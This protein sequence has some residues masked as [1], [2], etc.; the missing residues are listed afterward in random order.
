M[1][2]PQHLLG[3]WSDECLVSHA[4]VLCPPHAGVTEAQ[5]HMTRPIEG[6]E[7][8]QCRVGVLLE[9]EGLHRESVRF[10][11]LNEETRS[12]SPLQRGTRGRASFKL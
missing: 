2:Q 6:G 12:G 11:V 10:H 1:K 8:P 4:C 3:P 5:S 7:E 9:E